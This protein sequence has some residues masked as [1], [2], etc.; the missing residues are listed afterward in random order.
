MMMIEGVFRY[1]L[2]MLRVE[3]AV[4]GRGTHVLSFLP[5]QSYS[6]VVSFFLVIGG[7]VLWF[8]FGR[9]AGNI[10]GRA[11]DCVKDRQPGFRWRADAET[12]GE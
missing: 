4:I 7:A 6:M 11:G 10:A 1:V 12:K 2:E 8:V 3:P 9:I 5:P